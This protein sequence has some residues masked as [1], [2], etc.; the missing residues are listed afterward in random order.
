MRKSYL[1]AV[2]LI[3]KYK[4]QS[5]FVKYWKELAVVFIIPFLIIN[6]SVY[7]LY[8][9]VL[10]REAKS[11]FLNSCEKTS[12]V[13]ENIFSETD[14]LYNQLAYN[15]NVISY[16]YSSPQ[17]DNARNFH[18]TVSSIQ[19]L[20]ENFIFTKEYAESVYIYS[21][22]NDY[23][24][25]TDNGNNIEKFEDKS[26]YNH[27]LKTG[28]TDFIIPLKNPATGEFE[29]ITVCYGVYTG[30][31]LAGMIVCN[32]SGNYINALINSDLQYNLRYLCIVD[33][34][35]NIIYSCTQAKDTTFDSNH[36]LW[37]VYDNP[38]TGEL[39][40]HNIENEMYLSKTLLSNKLTL[41]FNANRE[42]LSKQTHGV[43]TFFTVCLLLAILL[44]ILMSLYISLKF[45]RSIHSIITSLSHTEGDVEDSNEINYIV[46]NIANITTANK[47]FEKELISKI[48][49]LK[50]TQTMAL[51]LQ[52]NPHF[53][54]NTLNM[55]NLLVAGYTNGGNDANKAIVLLSDLLYA[56]M[57]TN[58]YIITLQDELD[59][60]KKYIEI[61]KIQYEDSFE[62]H[63]DIDENTL[64]FKVLKLM[65]QPII[66][67]SFHYGLK[68]M[69]PGE[70]FII[71]IS[72]HIVNKD[73]KITVFNNGIGISPDRLEEIRNTLKNDDV[74]KEKHLG[75]NNINQRIKLL[76]GNKYGCSIDSDEHSFT[77]TITLPCQ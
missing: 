45:Y 65:L 4:W 11:S 61:L 74:L 53:L 51:Q 63:W 62:I 21:F 12:M 47:N 1:F 73:L 75:L 30:K 56:S 43:K 17:K 26:W 52:F 70:L 20:T 76:H 39:T 37:Q 59:Y 44:P 58:D 60:E 9:N 14:A 54:F 49:Q 24:L 28:R 32:L 69:P 18:L 19:T 34:D 27:Y 64:H 16:L 7:L 38:N 57:N 42:Y 5:I 25:S 67:N 8:S 50:R 6:S 46:S 77:V 10:N 13:L 72:S 29:R 22:F 15:N 36:P 48:Q 31:T 71:K 66:E 41:I 40:F 68:L 2:N 23:V 35:K 55:I 3:K 33:N